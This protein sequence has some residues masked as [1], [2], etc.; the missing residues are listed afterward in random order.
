MKRI[1]KREGEK[2]E[3]PKE[4]GVDGAELKFEKR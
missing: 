1:L 3:L 2:I 4:M